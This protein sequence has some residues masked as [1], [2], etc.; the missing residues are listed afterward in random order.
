MQILS[1]KTMERQTNPAPVLIDAQRDG[2]LRVNDV[3]DTPA[4]SGITPVV[5]PFAGGVIGPR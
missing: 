3:Y 1:D 4:P 2:E 5:T